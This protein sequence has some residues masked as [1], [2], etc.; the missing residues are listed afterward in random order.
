[1]RPS[2][3]AGLLSSSP[4]QDEELLKHIQAAVTRVQ[5]DCE[6]L[7]SV[8]GNLMDDRHQRQRDIEVGL[9]AS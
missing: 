6:K 9:E 5:G 1:M 4:K 3:G 7:S 2:H 8:T